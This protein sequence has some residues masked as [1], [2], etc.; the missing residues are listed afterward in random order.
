MSLSTLHFESHDSFVVKPEHKH[1]DLIRNVGVIAHIDAGKTTVTERILYHTGRIHRTGEVHDGAATMDYMDEERE[2]GITITSAATSATWKKNT[3]N[4]IDTP[5]HVDFTAEVERSLRVLDGVVGIFCGVAGVEAQS[6]TVWRQATR[7]G[8]PRIAFINKLDR[9][10]ADFMEAVDSIRARLNAVAIPVQYP[11]IEEGGLVGLIDLV[12]RVFHRFVDAGTDVTW[13]VE[14][15]PAEFAELAEEHFVHLLETAADYCDNI[16]EKYLEGDELSVE[17]IRHALREGTLS[18][19][20]VPVLGGTALKHKGVE[21]LLDGIGYYLP[22]PLN[23]PIVEG[24][25]P[26]DDEHMLHW[27]SLPESPLCALA[28]KT[29]AD[30]NGDLTFVR[31][32]SGI[33]RRGDVVFN[34]RTGKAERIG[35]LFKMHADSREAIEEAQAGDIVACVGMKNTITGDTLCMK[36]D[37]IVME[38]INF[39]D[40]I[41]SMS[42]APNSHADRDK[43]STT[44]SRL[45]K[46]DPT[47]RFY[48][49]EETQ[50]IIIAGMGELHLE[51]IKN[52][53]IREFR[54][55][56]SVGR[57]EV[58][59]KQAL[60]REVELQSRHV[61]QS[62]GHGQF[63]V[64][65]VRIGP[66]DGSEDYTF[67]ES[68]VSGSVPKEYFRAIERGIAESIKIGGE[69]RYPFV[70][71]HVE[72][73]D[74][75]YHEV[76]SSEMAFKLAAQQAFAMAVARAGTKLMEPVMV[77][78]IQVPEEFL[79][80]VLGDLNTR[81]AQVESMDLE[82]GV[83]VLKG[84]VPLAETFEYATVIRGL[85]QGRGTYSLEPCEY[86]DVPKSIAEKVALERRAKLAERK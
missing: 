82:R 80:D 86:A 34:P 8:V 10:G 83:R 79:G 53:I 58:A 47:F 21:Q 52:R 29:I 84:K 41:V 13:Q 36:D 40:P 22:S 5:G 28:F 56:V 63:A 12:E 50:E 25:R 26:G 32:Y 73:F 31:V 62:G 2:R 59:Y 78:D 67:E 72:L 71:V 4:I 57:P 7:Y 45:V 65:D 66:N 24:R 30:K 49:D 75:A 6:E 20:L 61:K 9:T 1:L 39:P 27:E 38:A 23:K 19:N 54:L 60:A 85:T 11:I 77:F 74:G 44:L 48:T 68:I 76:D 55:S 69:L 35:R 37:Q 51:V 17:E 81:R 70:N 14:E 15:I 64:I 16:M 18:G 46:E 42:I 33:L 3:L 43:L